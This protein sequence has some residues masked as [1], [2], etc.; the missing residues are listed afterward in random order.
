MVRQ[1]Y[2]R[3]QDL[4]V[5]HRPRD[6]LVR[7]QTALTN[8]IRG[9]LIEY[10]IA[11]AQGASPLRRAMPSI[12]ED[13]GNE[14]TPRFR[15]LLHGQYERHKA[16]SATIKEDDTEIGQVA[17]AHPICQRLMTIPG[18]GPKV[19]TAL[20]AS[21]GNAAQFRT[22]RDLAVRPG[23]ASSRG[24]IQRAAS[25]NSSALAAAA[26]DTCAGCWFI[27]PDLS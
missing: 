3:Q 13:A 11:I 10:G 8:Q 23:L 17:S 16:V 12:L 9:F 24:R 14:L 27:A 2:N 26:T 25:P 4:Q 21:I 6:L 22:G 20:L 18:V 1:V 19:A 15:Q 5:L 7:Q